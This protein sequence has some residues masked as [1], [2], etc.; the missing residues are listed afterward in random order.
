MDSGIAWNASSCLEYIDAVDGIS[1]FITSLREYFPLIVK[2]LETF[3]IEQSFQII[4][5]L[6]VHFLEQQTFWKTLILVNE[7]PGNVGRLVVL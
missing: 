3:L 1:R 6:F 5:A 4:L 2:T 7:P